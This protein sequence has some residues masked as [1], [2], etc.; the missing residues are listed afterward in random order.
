MDNIDITIVHG[1]RSVKPRRL[2]AVRKLGPGVAKILV[3]AE[4]AQRFDIVETQGEEVK[5][6]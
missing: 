2:V 3:V 6:A 4:F 1:S 5:S